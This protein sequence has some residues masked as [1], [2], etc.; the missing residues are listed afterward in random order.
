MSVV[1]KIVLVAYTLLCYF[2][3]GCVALV[4]VIPLI[5]L[6]FILPI[7]MCHNNRLIFFLLD[8]LYRGVTGALL[9]PITI[10]GE[11]HIPDN[12]ALI[13]AN[14][15]SALDV[16]MLGSVL[17]KKPHVWYA[18][19]YYASKPVIGFFIQRLGI[20]V[21]RNNGSAA[22]KSLRQGVKHAQ[23][24]TSNI[25]IFP[26]GGRYIDGEIHPFLHG[27]AFLARTTQRPVV[28]V[29][30]PYNGYVYPPHSFFIYWHPLEVV[31][32]PKFVYHEKDTDE[33]FVARVH[34][35][36]VHQAATVQHIK[37]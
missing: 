12:S 16:L 6:L 30:M 28:P 21:D 17:N 5:V 8:L 32:G 29:F 7:E 1:G 22:A 18:L 13:V 27:F 4:T 37:Q 11:E 31:I 20:T 36:F 9:V 15:Q 3:A 33:E 19:S 24:H 35:W 23:T 2:L 25:L 14:H 26:E 10:T 34:A